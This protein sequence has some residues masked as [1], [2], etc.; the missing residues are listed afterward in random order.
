MWA[1]T[2]SHFDEKKKKKMWLVKIVYNEMFSITVQL[3]LK[4]YN[5]MCH[6]Q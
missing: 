6:A 3:I 1:A 5:Q 2:H 4:F